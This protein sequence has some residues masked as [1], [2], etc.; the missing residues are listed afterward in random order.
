MARM[1]RMKGGS[2]IK[3]IAQMA[4]RKGENQPHK[5][6]DGRCKNKNVGAVPPCPF[7]KTRYKMEEVRRPPGPGPPRAA[8]VFKRE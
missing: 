3:R 4:R 5:N 1:A 7:E 2:R 8:V 6:A